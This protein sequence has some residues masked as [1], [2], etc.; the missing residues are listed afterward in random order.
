VQVNFNHAGAKWLGLAYANL[1]K[2]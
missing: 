2:S 1:T